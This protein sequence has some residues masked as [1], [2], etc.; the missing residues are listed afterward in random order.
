MVHNPTHLGLLRRHCSHFRD[1]HIVS[2]SL[3][4]KHNQC[5]PHL[6][7]STHQRTHYKPTDHTRQAHTYDHGHHDTKRHPAYGTE[8]TDATKHTGQQHRPTHTIPADAS[9]GTS[10]Q[11][12]THTT[13]T[14]RAPATGQAA[15]GIQQ[16]DTRTHIA[17]HHPT[18][19]ACL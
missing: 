6:A 15:T 8:P 2:H 10:R 12:T 19:A 3:A 14:S 1:T 16:H 13:H 7:H 4:A 9:Y 18:A 17:I 11:L 5:R